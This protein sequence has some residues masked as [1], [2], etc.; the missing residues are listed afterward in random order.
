MAI[1]RINHFEAKAGSEQAL[2]TFLQ[3]VI[4]VVKACD[5]CIDCVLLQ[6]V[7]STASLV[8]IEQWDSIDSHQKAASAIP[9]EKLQAA[10]SLFAKPASGSYFQEAN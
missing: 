10:F 3:E 5:G 2:F 9:K 1:T 8:I 6:G 7:D 4:S